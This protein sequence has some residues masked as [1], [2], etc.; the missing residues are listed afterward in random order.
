VYKYIRQA[1]A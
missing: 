1:E